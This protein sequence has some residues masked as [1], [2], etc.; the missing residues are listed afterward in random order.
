MGLGRIVMC[1]LL[2]AGLTTSGWIIAQSDSSSLR[3]PLDLPSGG[4]GSDRDEED[5]PETISF[6]GGE[7]EGDGF[8]WCLDKSC[9]MGWADEI[10]QLKAE[11]TSALSALSSEADFSLV[12]F[13]SGHIVW[14]AVPKPANTTNRAL[15]TAWVQ[16]LQAEGW[17]C[18]G[19]A[20][21]ETVNIANLS[22]KPHRQILVLSDGEPY[23][24]GENTAAASLNSITNSNWEHVP[25]N[26]IYIASDMGGAS[27]MQQLAAMNGGTFHQP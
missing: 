26:T 1:G 27:F 3:R 18:L 5:A 8:F 7:Y 11:V 25:I 19:P 24:D 4:R 9:S 22:D 13:S 20:G 6:Y 15:A 14:S 12:A 2:S 17:T 10:G 23:C 21:V 16:A